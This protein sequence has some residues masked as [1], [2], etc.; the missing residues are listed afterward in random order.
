MTLYNEYEK[1]DLVRLDIDITISGSFVDPTH[2]SLYVTDP[3]GEEDHFIYGATGT[4]I[5]DAVGRYYLDYFTHF[6]GQY[7]YRFFCSGTAWGAEWKQF[8]VKRE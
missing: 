3:T 1:G 2:L 7:K 5:K 8:V 6:S 4:F